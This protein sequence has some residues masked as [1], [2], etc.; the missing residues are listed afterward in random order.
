MNY[1][2]IVIILFIKKD[3]LV[4]TFKWVLMYITLKI[5]MISHILTTMFFHNFISPY[6]VQPVC[7]SVA[8]RKPKQCDKKLKE[9]QLSRLGL[10]LF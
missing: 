3:Y 1:Q 6:F 4:G 2:T 8:L 7:L 5:G 10:L 9:K